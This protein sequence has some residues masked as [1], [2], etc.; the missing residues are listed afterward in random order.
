[1]IEEAAALKVFHG[2]FNAFFCHLRKNNQTRLCIAGNV[3]SSMV[4]NLL[5]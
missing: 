5:S 3:K 4:L 2:F 1:V